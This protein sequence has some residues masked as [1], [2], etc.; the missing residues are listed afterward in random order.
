[1]SRPETSKYLMKWGHDF[2]DGM[3]AA[4]SDA[5]LAKLAEPRDETETLATCPQC[6]CMG[7]HHVEVKVWEARGVRTPDGG[8]IDMSGFG[9]P[10]PGTRVI[11]RTCI[12]CAHSWGR[13]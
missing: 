6:S 2:V 12:F 4:L 1:V 8:W 9:D 10:L 13:A 11:W 3:S 7:H 5:E